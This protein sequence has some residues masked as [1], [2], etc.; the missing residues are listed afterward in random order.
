[1]R[2]SS[3]AVSHRRNRIMLM[4]TGALLVAGFV[5]RVFFLRRHA[6]IPNDALL[7]QEI[8]LN[9]MHEHVYGLSTDAAPRPTLIRLP[10]YPAILAACAF[11]FR[12]WADDT[13]TLRSF[14]PVLWL[15]I[16]ADLL[17][18]W[19]VSRIAQRLFGQRA[20][21]LAL[22]LA[23]LCPFT[24]NYTAT[25]LTETF[26]LTLLALA[27][28]LLLRWMERP[29]W[30]TL[31]LLSVAL[32]GSILLRP[33][34][35]LLT[36]AILP[37]VFMV[38]WKQ[39]S[40]RT[41]AASVAVCLLLI[42]LAFV[43]WTVRNYRTFDVFQPLVPPLANDPGEV[44]PRAFQ[45]WFRTWAIDFSATEDA[46]WIYPDQPVRLADLPDR[47]FDSAAQRART[48]F[49]LDRAGAAGTL[50][51]SVERGFDQMAWERERSHPLRTILLP[52]ARLANMLLHPRTEMLP[53]AE[54]WWQYRLHP[55]Q[56]VFAWSYAALNFAYLAAAVAGWRRTVA[57][58]RVL[59]LS[60]LGYIVLRCGL[61]LT[62]DNAEQRYTLEFFPILWILASSLAAKRD[63]T[64]A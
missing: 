4:L 64:P 49:L 59:A 26:T 10:G 15:Q 61:L 46:Y 24:A 62:L 20:G 1:M 9:W 27:F 7:Y 57:A 51:P 50:D 54:R 36:V 2:L 18:C 6:F 42:F 53:V 31:V 12:R 34:Q 32:S 14:L 23:A 28:H 17:T 43:P 38:R 55:A 48:E 60:M 8:A 13:G 21:L 29:R 11:L 58:N 33:D 39:S 22:A 40:V 25:P 37:A 35:G 56:T 19:L 44:P 41:A 45:H 16:A 30:I 52:V 5:L 63:N 3:P 47:A